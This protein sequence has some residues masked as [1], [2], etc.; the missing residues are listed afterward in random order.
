MKISVIMA[1][2]NGREYLL[3][4]LNSI[5]EQ[6]H[7]IDEL[8]ICDDCSTNP[9]DDI[10][11][12]F[13]KDCGFKI[14]YIKNAENLG[15]AQN[16]FKVLFLSNGDWVFL[17]D[18]DD[19]WE[20]NKVSSVLSFVDNCEDVWCVSSL[21]TIIDAEGI[22]RRREKRLDG[23][24]EKVVVEDLIRQTKL[25]AGMTLAVSRQLI[26]E[27]KNWNTGV[28]TEHD[29]L[30]ECVACLNQGFYL[31]NKYLVQYRIHSTNTSGSINLTYKL[32]S[33]KA[34]RIKQIDKE[35]R[36]LRNLLQENVVKEN[37]S[38]CE[39]INKY[40]LYY[41]R[42]KERLAEGRIRKYLFDLPFFSRLSNSRRILL[43]DLMS[44]IQEKYKAQ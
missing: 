41:G 11:D 22:E 10:I 29:R 1:L 34:G 37:D 40:L 32:M 3:E 2:Y 27:L 5:K 16:F 8:I 25:R 23:M 35:M 42:R 12:K 17:A 24:F 18:Q 31:L 14:N 13:Q 19:I 9:C 15:Y 26:S 38:I 21:S 39:S 7:R 20:K 4:Q 33:D 43:G 44:M 36:Y 28:Y 30:I 6:D